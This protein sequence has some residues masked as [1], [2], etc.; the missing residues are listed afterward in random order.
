MRGR[1]AVI[2]AVLA[3]VEYARKDAAAVGTPDPAIC[4]GPEIWHA[5]G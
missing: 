1:I 5:D 3:R 2:Q 4:G